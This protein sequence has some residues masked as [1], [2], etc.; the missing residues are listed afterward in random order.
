[1]KKLFSALSGGL[2]AGRAGVLCGVVASHGSTPRGAGAKMLVWEDGGALGTIGGGTVEY[3]AGQMARQLLRDGCSRFESYRLSAGES[4]GVGMICGGD[5]Q[6]YFQCFDPADRAARETLDRVL[7]LLGA[8]GP[9]WLVT[10]MTDT[11][12]RMGT[13]DPEHGL[14]GLDVPPQRLERLLG[15]EGILDQGEPVLFVEPLVRPGTVYL[16]GAGHVARELAHILAMTDFRV[17]VWDERPEEDWQDLFP[18]A[19]RRC[20]GPFRRALERLGPLTAEDYVVIMTPGHQAD[21]EVLAQALRTPAKYIG[22]IGSRRKTALTRERL[23]AD[24]FTEAEIG[25]VNAPIGLPI[26]GKTPAEV[27]VSAAA[28]L[29]ACRSGRLAALTGKE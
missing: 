6:V 26:G 4:A 23:L 22:C 24:G 10:A 13:C 7:A 27:A 29:I 5:V 16:F 12:W 11:D 18:E 17:A 21:Y 2:A 15:G 14:L 9:S 19:A 8:P 25:R 20:R 3:R 28:Q 1:M